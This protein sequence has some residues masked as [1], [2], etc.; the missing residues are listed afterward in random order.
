MT[1]DILPLAAHFLAE[2]KTL[3]ASAQATLLNHLGRATC[4][5]SRT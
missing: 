1:D 3:H 5:S 4:E 2:G